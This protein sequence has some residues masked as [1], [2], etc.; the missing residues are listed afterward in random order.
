[1]A[2]GNLNNLIAFRTKDQ[3]TQEFINETLG[4]TTIHSMK[5]G[6]NTAR[7]GHFTDFTAVD[8]TQLSE[9]VNELVPASIL[10]KLPNL[11]FFASVSGGHVYKGR[12]TLIDPGADDVSRDQK[13]EGEAC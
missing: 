2:L 5:F 8:S 3:P 6:H 4:Q 10:G 9:E 7:D 11:Q 1:M 12:F 13:E